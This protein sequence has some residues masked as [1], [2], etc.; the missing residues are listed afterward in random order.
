[1]VVYYIKKISE[2]LLD[3]RYPIKEGDICLLYDGEVIKTVYIDS[4]IDSDSIWRDY[5]FIDAKSLKSYQF[6]TL[7]SILC[8]PFGSKHAIGN[9]GLLTQLIQ[10]CKGEWLLDFLNET[11]AILSG[12]VDYWDLE[13]LRRLT[14]DEDVKISYGNEE[15]LS[16]FTNMKENEDVDDEEEEFED[17]EDIEI[18]PKNNDIKWFCL[19]V[20]TCLEGHINKRSYQILY[21]TLRGESRAS[22]ASKYYLSQERIRQ[23]VVKTTKQAKEILIEQLRN[24]EEV[25]AENSKLNIQINL[26]KEDIAGLKAL[27]PKEVIISKEDVDEDLSTDL[28]KLLE[29][30]IGDIYLPARAVNILLYMKVNKFADI[31]QIK[32]E[33][34][35]LNMRNSG[36]KTVHD[37]SH[38]LKDFYLTFGMSYTE[39]VNVLKD[40]DWHSAKKKW[41][42]DSGH[43]KVI[44]KIKDNE[45]NE[46]ITSTSITHPGTT[47]NGSQVKV[48]KRIGYIVKLFPS[49]QVGEIVNVRVDGRGIKKLVVKTNKGNIMV[50]DDFPYLYEVLKRN[51]HFETAANNVKQENTESV[52]PEDAT[53]KLTKEIIEAARTPNGGFTKSQLAAIGINW[54][55]PLNWIEEKI[56]TMISPTQL[57]A[58]N[59]IEY[60][61]KPSSTLFQRKDIKTYKDVAFNSDE[62]KKMEAILQAM[63]NFLSPVT[64]RVI[65][66]TID[67]TLWGEEDVIKEYTVDSFLKR[68]PE[69]EYVKWGKYILKNRNR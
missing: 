63:T 4:E 18:L 45:N 17:E 69:V 66:R 39:I 61:T 54:P 37:I 38:M 30:P 22:I 68:L 48:D 10:E 44:N 57:K 19:S 58:F 46:K 6:S 15:A 5:K 9:T 33:L 59:H 21:D 24:L 34:T 29:T 47:T 7:D 3:Y 41:I 27:L 16:E 12:F 23:I 8:A 20:L 2:R 50:V 51:V 32:S 13:I 52:I 1:M 36:R 55:P 43:T 62:R 26:L 42:R 49:Q 31:P 40:K 64:P 28:T 14:G 56:G 25:K 11:S 65:A 67:Q 53:I 35:L 60:V